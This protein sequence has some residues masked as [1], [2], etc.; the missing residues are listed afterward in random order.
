MIV[1][2]IETSCDETAAAVVGPQ[3]PLADI[4]WSQDVHALYGGVVPELAARAH[5]EK[6]GVAAAAALAEAGIDRPDA[7]VATAGPGLIGAVLVGLAWAKAAAFGW[8]VPFL[9]VNHL[10]GHLLSATIQA[11][12]PSFPFLALVVSGGHTTLYR[13]D[14]VGTYAVLAET[15][16]DAAG[17]AYDKVA[18]M[19]GLGYPGGPVIDRLAAEGNPEAVAF[20]RPLEGSL[21]VSFAGLKTAVRAHLMSEAR[22][23]DADVAASFQAAVIDVLRSRVERVARETGIPRVAIGGGVAANRGLRD[24]LRATG[25]EVHI[26]PMGH[27]T[28]NAVMIAHAG[29]QRLLRGEH[30]GLDAGARARWAVA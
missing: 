26:P 2:G 9:G 22:A 14:D 19:M 21:D 12:G 7:V 10:E 15:R 16:D 5:A 25:L 17:E 13:A 4:V 28:D 11:G 6:V 30:D 24:A 27:C 8:G 1:L 20:P 23:A 3:G 18:R 29:R